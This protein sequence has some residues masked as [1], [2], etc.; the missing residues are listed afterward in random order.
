[1]EECH[2][3]EARQ[4]REAPKKFNNLE[5]IKEMVDGNLF[6]PILKEV[7]GPL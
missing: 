6:I 7:F 5:V 1:M 4:Q 3:S 2:F